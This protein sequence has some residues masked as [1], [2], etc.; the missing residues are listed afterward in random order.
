MAAN[1]LRGLP[2]SLYRRARSLPEAREERRFRP[3][4]RVDPAAPELVVSPHLDDAVLDC[5]SVLN[6]DR[7]LRVVNVFAG[8]PENVGLTGWDAI[9]GAADSAERARERIAE[10]AVA[11]ARVPR[12]P[13]NLDLLDAQYR[14]GVLDRLGLAGPSL[15]QIDL[16]V[17]SLAA[18]RVAR[19]RAGRDRRPR[20]PRARPPLRADAGAGRHARDAV[21]GAA[22]LRGLRMALVGGWPRARAQPE[23]RCLLELLRRGLARDAS[24]AVGRRGAPR[25]R[26]RRGEA[27]SD[28]VLSHAIPLPEL[29]R[30]GPARR[31]RDPPLRGS[32]G[33]REP[34]AA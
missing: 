6:S 10:D 4:L 12:E 17:V 18:E 15:D 33:A 31:S 19:V 30:Q 7:E 23:R 34:A 1:S 3:R 21:R 26:R 32:L 14:T 13:F 28:E 16:A 9:T 2:R 5:F 27:R 22:L 11:L 29:W 24:P 8:V 25:R 20:R